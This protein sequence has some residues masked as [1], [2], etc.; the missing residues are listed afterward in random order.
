MSNLST[1]VSRIP[2]LTKVGMMR[3]TEVD[4][5]YTTVPVIASPIVPPIFRAKLGTS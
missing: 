3:N 1:Y 5:T 2:F 4:T